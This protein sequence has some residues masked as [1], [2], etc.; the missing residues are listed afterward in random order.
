MGLIVLQ[1]FLDLELPEYMATIITYLQQENMP[2]RVNQI[3]IN[4]GWM[5]ACAVGSLGSAVL[6]N[7]FVSKISGRLSANIR[8][9]LYGKIESFSLTEINKF[10]T[11]S[12]MTRTTNDISNVQ[13]LIAMG[14]Q[15]FLKAPVMAIW[16]ITK[17]AGLGWEWAL[18]DGNKRHFP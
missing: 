17:I 13:M 16:A 2:D 18:P 1:T 11:A 15:S 9:A 3:L 5:L 10:S 14:T 8:S 7:F 4:G 12:L 6:V